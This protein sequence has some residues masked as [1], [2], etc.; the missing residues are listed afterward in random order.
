MRKSRPKTVKEAKD[1]M[2]AAI[3]EENFELASYYWKEAESLENFQS[4]ISLGKVVS[5][6]LDKKDTLTTK[7]SFE[8][9][10]SFQEVEKLKEKVVSDYRQRFERL[11][12]KQRDELES[13]LEEWKEARESAQSVAEDTLRN[14][15]QTAK[16]LAEQKQFDEAIRLRDYAY[17]SH[18]KNANKKKKEVDTHYINLMKTMRTRHQHQMSQLATKKSNDVELLNQMLESTESNTED[19]FLLKNATFVLDIVKRYPHSKVIPHSLKAQVL[20][21]RI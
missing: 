16:I 11:M 2:Q 1:L 4:E 15:I 3:N 5:Q 7:M 8:A 19:Q 17:S 21:N 13:A 20:G 6:Y 10:N 9:N 18:E 12:S 14:T